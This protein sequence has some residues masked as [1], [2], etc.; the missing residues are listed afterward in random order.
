M[1]RNPP[2]LWFRPKRIGIGYSPG[3]WEGWALIGLLVA[4][5]MAAK[6]LG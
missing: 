3:T 1:K 2:Q 6:A 4:A 5:A